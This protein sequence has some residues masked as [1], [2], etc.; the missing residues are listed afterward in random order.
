MKYWGI[1]RGKE[2]VDFLGRP[3]IYTKKLIA[4]RNAMFASG[5]T[6]HEVKVVKVKKGKK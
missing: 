3:F 1:F 4:E 2:L 5:E 6:V